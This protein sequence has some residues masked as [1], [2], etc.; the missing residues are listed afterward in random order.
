MV[1]P[2]ENPF[3]SHRIERLTPHPGDV[4]Q[5]VIGRLEAVGWRGAIVGSHG[6]GK[7]VLVERLVEVLGG[8]GHL[9]SLRSEDT[10]PFRGVVAQL[11]VSL[12]GIVVVLDGAEQ[13]GMVAWRR[14][15]RRVRRA[16]GLVVTQHAEG[17]LPTLWR[18]ATSPGL[19]GELVA[20]LAPDLVDSVSPHLEELWRRHNGNL[21]DCFSELYDRCA[22]DE[23]VLSSSYRSI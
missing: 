11:P 12:D 9:V 2:A 20:E 6:S 17:R 22:R 23:L 3:A 4:V 1:R 8:R 16:M 14:W 21:R 5:R 10:D 18:C 7:T 15:C 19:L 13:L